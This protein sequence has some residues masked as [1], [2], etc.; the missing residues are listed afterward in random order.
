MRANL[1]VPVSSSK[2]LNYK[3]NKIGYVQLTSFTDGSGA[4]VDGRS[5]RCSPR[6]PRR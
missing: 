4:E 5:T 3:G 1:V 6:A 2:I